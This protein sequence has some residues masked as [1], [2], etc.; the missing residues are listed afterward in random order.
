MFDRLG[1]T[2][3]PLLNEKVMCAL[4]RGIARTG[5]LNPDGT[6][7]ALANLQRFVALARALS[8]DHLAIIATAAVREA[9]DGRAFAAEAERRCGVPVRIIEGTEEARLSAAG[10]LAGIRGADGVV[11]DLGGG[12]VELVPID[13]AA[14]MPIG[15]GISLPIGPLRLT[16]LGDR[17]KMADFVE[18]KIADASV[19]G[20]AAGKSLYLVGGAW[21]AL[22]RLHMEQTQYPLHIIH[23]YAMPRQAAERFLDIVAGQSRR[24][25][26]RITSISRKRLE[27]L[28]VAA[29]ILRR[30][31]AAGKPSRIVFSAFGLREGYAYGLLPSEPMA[32]GTTRCSLPARASPRARADGKPT[33]TGSIAGSR[34]SSP[35]RFDAARRDGAAPGGVL[36]QR[37]GLE[38]A[39]GLPRRARL[40]AHAD[41]AVPADRP[42]RARL[43]RVGAARPLWRQQRRSGQGADPGAARRGR[44]GRGARAR[45]RLAPRLY[46][47][48]RRVDSCSTRFVSGATRAA[49]AL[50][51]PPTGSLFAGEAVTRRLDALGRALAV[52]ARTLRRRETAAAEA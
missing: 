25:L 2:L 35:I 22:A 14:A 36:A 50:E 7:L 12:S 8:V 32:T 46:A 31:I 24:S 13:A 47:V 19:L 49:I 34:R 4:G 10:V 52:P 37:H 40:R 5:R 6:E 27:L 28:P 16:E 38:R 44:S 41:P 18:R 15:A 42:R 43:C 11:A 3:T 51:L 21:R 23:E 45:S 39:P 29:L 26:E 30:L 9:S 17:S 48:R 1:A 20:A 33:A